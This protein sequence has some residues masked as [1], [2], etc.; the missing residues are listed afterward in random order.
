MIGPTLPVPD[1]PP[2]DLDHGRQLGAGAAQEDLVGHVQLGA[3][4][5]A[6]DD[7]DAEVAGHGDDVLA[8]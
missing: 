4:D 5:G 2:I 1:R 8:A 6:L 7:R 3:V